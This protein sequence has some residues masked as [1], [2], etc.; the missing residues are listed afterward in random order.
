MQSL[1]MVVAAVFYALYGMFVKFAGQ[2]SIGSWE[3]LFFR[4]VFCT[5]VFFVALKAQHLNLT[6]PYPVH[7]IIR[8]VAG[9]LAMLFGIYSISHLNLGLAMTLNYTA[10]LFMG[11]F[12]VV[13]SML[14]HSR[15]NWGLISMVIVGFIGVIVLLG[16]TIGPHEYYAAVVGLC[17]G[18][19]TAVA[20]LYVKKLGVLHEPAAKIIF[21]LVFIGTLCGLAGTLMT[22]GFHPWSMNAAIYI[23]GLSVCACLGQFTL[24]LAFSRGNLVLSS[25]LQYT[26]ILFATLL[27]E[28]FFHEPATWTGITGMCIIVFAGIMSSYYV[29]KENQLKVKLKKQ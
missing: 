2:E 8:S 25:S 6:T 12:V 15:I 7:H 21:Y 18:L 26:V 9:T 22:G 27:G 14:H 19:M 28:I 20:T 3:V 23:A 13:T 10:P 1:W 5:A 11:T 17:A 4:S 24:T 29:R 16:P